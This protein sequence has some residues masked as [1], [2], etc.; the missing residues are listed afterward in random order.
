LK[1][2]NKKHYIANNNKLLSSLFGGVRREGDWGEFSTGFWD[3]F[4]RPK[5]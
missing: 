3:F 5:I 1:L 4:I 2:L